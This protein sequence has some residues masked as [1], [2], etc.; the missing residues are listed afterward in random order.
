M[1]KKIFVEKCDIQNTS[2]E[3]NLGV[4]PILD[5]LQQTLSCCLWVWLSLMFLL[6]QNDTTYFHTLCEAAP[7]WIYFL[8][9]MIFILCFTSMVYLTSMI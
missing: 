9:L 8:V 6:W 5:L 1:L 2:R 4:T 3:Y 7:V